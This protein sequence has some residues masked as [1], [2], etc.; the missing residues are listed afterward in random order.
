MAKYIAMKGRQWPALD[1]ARGVH[2][3]VPDTLCDPP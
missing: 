3:A 1:E 2:E